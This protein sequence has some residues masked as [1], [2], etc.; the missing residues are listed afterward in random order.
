MKPQNM[1][2]LHDPENGFY[3]DCFRACIASL[4]HMPT[5]QVPH[6]LENYGDEPDA[7]F[8]GR[9]NLWLNRHRLVF[10]EF[11]TAQDEDALLQVSRA[12]FGDVHYVL[13][14]RSKRGYNHNAIYK[15]GEL[16][17]DPHPEGG[18]IVGPA[19]DGFYWLGFLARL[20]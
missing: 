9:M 7:D 19:E 16:V 13:L 5:E 8:I 6:V 10:I 20:T 15:A 17:H 2:V 18:G 4:L 11:P 3:G 1:L 12:Y 14:G